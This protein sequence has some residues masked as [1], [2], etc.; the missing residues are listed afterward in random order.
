MSRWT[1]SSSASAGQPGRPRRLQHEPSCIT[2]PFVSAATSQCWASVIP[3]AEAYSRARRISWGSCT[4]LPSSVNSRTPAAASSPNGASASPAR[5]MVMH[6]A[7][8]HLAQPGALA[9][10]ADELDDGHRV[11]RRLGVRH[12]HD[13]GEPAERRGARAG[14]D[15]LRL[16]ASRLA[17]V[18][19]EVDEPGRDDAAVRLEHVVGVADSARRIDRDHHAVLDGHVGIRAGLVQHVPPWITSAHAGTRRS[20]DADAASTDVSA[21]AGVIGVQFRSGRRDRVTRALILAPQPVARTEQ[22]E[23]HGHAHRHA[24]GHLVEDHRA[25]QLGRVDRHLDAAIH[26][27][28]VHHQG[29]RR[30]PRRPCGRQAVHRRVLAQARQQRLVHPLS[31]HT[32]Q[33]Q[34]VEVGDQRVEVVADV[35]RP[36][37]ERRRQQRRR[38]DERDV[39]AERG[40]RLHV[41]ARHPAVLDVADDGDAQ[42]VEPV[43]P[44]EP[45]ADRVA[46]EQRLGGVLVPTV[47]G[48]DDRRLGPLGDLL[49]G[50]A[51]A[52]ADDERVDAHRA[53]RLDRVAQALALVQAARRHGEVHR[54]GRQPLGRG[55]EAGACAR[56]VLEEQA[57]HVLA[58]QRRHLGDR[59]LADLG[60]VVGELQQPVDVGGGEVLDRQQVLHAIV[61]PSIVTRTSS[62]RLVGRFLPT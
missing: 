50:A 19:V 61:T 59:P 58:A 7:G 54:V 3:S 43:A 38:G 4:P 60:H 20:A 33:V 32:Q 26:R 5:P 15:R 56:R 62:S 28:R 30:Q 13:R 29:V 18:H 34:D 41:A 37:V 57:D 11:L 8:Q 27:A 12:R 49:R 55:V 44:A 52:V 46:V 45:G 6:P 24:V 47:A 40:E 42:P 1:I 17:Q 16:L 9:L 51:R 2:A 36:A 35:H 14:L 53:D 31:L 21:T 25:G 22:A 39:R 23:E 10:G 48:V